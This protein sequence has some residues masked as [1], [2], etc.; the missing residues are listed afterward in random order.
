MRIIVDSELCTGCETCLSSCPYDAIVMKDDKAFINE[1]CQ[2]D[3]K[4]VV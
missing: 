2:L 3:R 1:Y 4:S